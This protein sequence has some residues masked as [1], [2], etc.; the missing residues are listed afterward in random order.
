MIVIIDTHIDKCYYSEFIYKAADLIGVHRI[1]VG[2][3]INGGKQ[4]DK[5]NHFKVYLT[6]EKL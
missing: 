2:R 6:P 5:Y 4:S 1:T 3:W